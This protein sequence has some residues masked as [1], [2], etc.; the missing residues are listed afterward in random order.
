MGNNRTSSRAMVLAMAVIVALAAALASTPAAS[1]PATDLLVNESTGTSSGF[2]GAVVEIADQFAVPAGQT[3]RVSGI[4]MLGFASPGRQYTVRF[5]ANQN[6]FP[7]A[8][9]CQ[10]A[11]AEAIGEFVASVA[12][13]RNPELRLDSACVLGVGE[14]F[15][16][17]QTSSGA[18]GALQ[19]FTRSNLIGTEALIRGA[20][21]G[22]NLV[23]ISSCFPTIG[24][25]ELQFR[26]RGCRDTS[27]EFP[28]DIVTRCVGSNLELEVRDGDLP[29]LI[30][31]TGPGLPQTLTTFGVH[32][33][34]GP[35]LW[36]SVIANE[37]TGD[38]QQSALD[39]RNC[40]PRG[41][42]V[43]ESEG[44]TEVDEAQPAATDT[45]TL[46]LDSSPDAGET[47]TIGLDS[48]TLL[49]V[50][51]APDSITFD[52]SNWSQARTITVSAVDDAVLETPIHQDTIVHALD[53]TGGAFSG[54]IA[55]P[56][57]TV[58]IVDDEV[59]MTSL[60][61]VLVGVPFADITSLPAGITCPG[62]CNAM[63]ELQSIAELIA[64]TVDAGQFFGWG[65]ACSGRADCILVLDE[66]KRV[67]ATF[68]DPDAL[69]VNGFE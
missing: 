12:Q 6:G 10:T 25:R 46:V 60:E 55:V 66:P 41:V 63:F 43:V 39:G 27:C 17:L 49:G 26:I 57:V 24:A 58:D 42:T 69:M 20:S 61:V 31:G 11:D 22:T 14:Y 4:G 16:G 5:Y 34:P 3:W 56:D 33:V 8:I 47:V 44:S 65:G 1:A 32:S 38:S 62:A 52:S 45:Y 59:P 9:V 54:G 7:G 37:Q 35:G 53:S 23:P 29:V 13:V 21:C 15:V 19:I 48:D 28:V 36:Q 68:G 40:G 2:N 30:S 67:I 51:T 18:V 64:N 50:S